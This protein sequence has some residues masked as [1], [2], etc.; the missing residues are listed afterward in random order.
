VPAGELP[1]SLPP[2]LSPSHLT[3]TTGGCHA[4]R[5]ALTLSPSY[6]L[7]LAPS[8]PRTVAPS[9]PRTRSPAHPPTLSPSHPLI[10]SPSHSYT[11]PH[12]L[13]LLPSLQT[14]Q[15]Y[16]FIDPDALRHEALQVHLELPDEEV[17]ISSDEI[18]I[19]RADDDTEAAEEDVEEAA[20]ARL[21][22][23]AQAMGAAQRE[24]R[25]ALLSRR[26]IV[27]GA[28]Y[29]RDVDGPLPPPLLST[30]CVLCMDAE[31]LAAA[32]E[33]AGG[34]GGG[35]EGGDG[36]GAAGGSGFEVLPTE[37][38]RRVCEAARS[39]LIGL[40]DSLLSHDH[41]SHDHVSH[42]LSYD[43]EGRAHGEAESE[44]ERSPAGEPSAAAD[45]S[46]AALSA[47][48]PSAAEQLDTGG[49][50]AE[51]DGIGDAIALYVAF[52]QRVLQRA[53][54]AVT[55]LEA[56]VELAALS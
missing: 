40:A 20:Q 11:L 9:H 32:A 37:L 30:L 45:L 8:H 15:Y 12:T 14:L 1:P 3:S 54:A 27:L 2:T 55:A 51:V 50:D 26:G 28:H 44:A 22:A 49:G 6:P 21:M 18:A 39:L 31:E 35:E 19:Q 53:L 4:C 16:G 43:A 24:R 17:A 42:G 38:Q 23:A 36:E 25:E 7:T 47:V 52:Q 48:D 5:R 33:D 41:L 10:L 13:L 29:L 46:G 56:Q 34:E